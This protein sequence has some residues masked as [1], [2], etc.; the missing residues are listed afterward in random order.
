MA[1]VVEVKL[2]D[3]AAHAPKDFAR[4]HL[5]V[6]PVR[7]AHDVDAAMLAA[8]HNALLLHL[9]AAESVETFQHNRINAAGHGIGKQPRAAGTGFYVGRARN[10]LVGMHRDHSPAERIRFLTADARLIDDR[11]LALLV[12]AV[13]KVNCCPCHGVLRFGLIARRLRY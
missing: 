2:V 9:I 12:S 6:V 5:A 13:A 10:A 4:L 1:K 7:D 11:G 8:A 3:Q